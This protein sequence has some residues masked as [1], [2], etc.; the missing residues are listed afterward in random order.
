MEGGGAN[1]DRDAGLAAALTDTRF[2][3]RWVAGTGSTNDDLLA[4]AAAGEADGAVLVADHQDAGRGR[5]DRTWEAPAGASLLVS[6]LLR[7]DLPADRLH[8]LTTAVG[9]A[10]VDAVA[11]VAGVTVGLK[12]PN[13][14]VAP[15]P[16]GERKLGGI[17]AQA[18][19]DGD[20]VA[21]VVVG[22]GLNVN[23]ADVGP[24]PGLA[25]LAVA[26]DALAGHPVDRADLLVALLRALEGHLGDLD[27]VV[28][29]WRDRATTL[30][31]EV[32]V[33]LASGEVLE[34]T[35]ADLTADGHLLL[36]V[37][38]EAVEVTVGDVEHVRPG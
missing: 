20:E 3:V 29:A 16:A 12:W 4:A 37:D 33:H 38:G 25:D 26:L 24:P 2:R 22:L 32:R 1:T 8:L 31:R 6:V 21:A 23:W 28:G 27:G 19:W 18:A 5:R 14:L 36:L 17:L 7:P 9:V 15:T 11:E 35:A 34:G 13:D 30:G 10:A